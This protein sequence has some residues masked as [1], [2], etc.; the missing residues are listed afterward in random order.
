M[1]F[2]VCQF[3][4]LK[5]AV[6]S[7]VWRMDIHHQKIRQPLYKIGASCLLKLEER[8]RGNRGQYFQETRPDKAW[9]VKALSH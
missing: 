2:I 3:V 4:A 8:E 6:W 1:V 5:R 7:C 9:F